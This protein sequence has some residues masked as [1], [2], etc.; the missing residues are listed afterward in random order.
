MT[1]PCSA[2]SLL[3]E[4][5]IARRSLRCVKDNKG[6]EVVRCAC[7]RPAALLYS[8]VEWRYG[9]R[10][11][12]LLCRGASRSLQVTHRR[13][14]TDARNMWLL[15]LLTCLL[16][17]CLLHDG[18]RQ[19]SS[20]QALAI[21]PARFDEVTLGTNH[22]AVTRERG[23]CSTTVVLCCAMLSV[24]C[25]AVLLVLCCVAFSYHLGWRGAS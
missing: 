4:S 2:S 20:R 24:L 19:S 10:D 13:C 25:C 7:L 5:A 8:R 15:G 14:L 22:N 18:A 21:T 3:R 16:A 6:I 11:R 23:Y 17:G 12:L 1:C 9:P